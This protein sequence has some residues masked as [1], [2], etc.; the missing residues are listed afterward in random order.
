VD[1]GVADAVATGVGVAVAVA[2]GL[3]V[4]VA[5]GAV[6]VAAGGAGVSDTDGCGVIVSWSAERWQ[7]ASTKV[8]VT[9]ASARRTKCRRERCFGEVSI[10]T[11][12]CF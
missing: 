7:A 1:A 5:G 12:F 9:P 8:M 4:A 6:S 2:V 10:G 11:P 3:D